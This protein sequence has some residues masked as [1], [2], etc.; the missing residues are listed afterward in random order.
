ARN[1]IDCKERADWTALNRDACGT[2]RAGDAVCSNNIQAFASREQSLIV[3]VEVRT[4]SNGA[5]RKGGNDVG[6]C[7]PDGKNP[8][9]EKK[10]DSLH[11]TLLV[12]IEGRE[13]TYIQ[14]LW[15]L[16]GQFGD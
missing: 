12:A 1:V 16:E 14:I 8:K 5:T 6:V 15:Q 10:R 7:G 13:A 11:E 2:A 3:V 9:N 4:I